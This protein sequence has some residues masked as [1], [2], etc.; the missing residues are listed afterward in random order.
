MI[1]T[2]TED[3][4]GAYI[5]VRMITLFRQI[6]HHVRQNTAGNGGKLPRHGGKA[7]SKC[8][9]K[10]SNWVFPQWVKTLTEAGRRVVAFDN[11]GHGRSEKFYDPAAYALPKMTEDVR[12]V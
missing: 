5:P 8:W 9:N 7:C 1:V 3:H 10:G 12:V 6:R 4:L 11:R 2:G